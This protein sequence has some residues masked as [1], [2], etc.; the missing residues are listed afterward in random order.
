M[1]GR[2]FQQTRRRRPGLES[3]VILTHGLWQRRYGGDPG[4]VGR[5]VVINDR[6]RTVVGVMPP[7]FKFP[8]RDGALH[9][10]AIGRGAAVRAQHQ[11]RWRV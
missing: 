4:I 8:E 5:G 7:H 3:T 1:L 2:T 11:R 9:A 10:A 6:A